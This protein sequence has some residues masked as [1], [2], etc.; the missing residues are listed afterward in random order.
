MNNINVRFYNN[1]IKDLTGT[2]YST[3]NS[4]HS[5]LGFYVIAIDN[6]RPKDDDCEIFYR[7][8]ADFINL[9]NTSERLLTNLY[10]DTSESIS[11]RSSFKKLIYLYEVYH[12]I[13]SNDETYSSEQL[14]IESNSVNFKYENIYSNLQYGS[15]S[16]LKE[17]L[18]DDYRPAFEIYSSNN[19][20]LLHNDNL[21]TSIMGYQAFRP[22][23]DIHSLKVMVNLISIVNPKNNLFHVHNLNTLQVITKNIPNDNSYESYPVNSLTIFENPNSGFS[24]EQQETCYEDWNLLNIQLDN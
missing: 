13:K 7:S 21:F 24:I 17:V 19:D 16:K 6:S 18:N 20:N 8:K 5:I 14:N 1:F 3:G 22:I 2:D 15:I 9:E 11:M 23:I 4:I 12:N 10:T